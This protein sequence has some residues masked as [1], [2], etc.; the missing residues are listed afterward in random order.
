MKAIPNLRTGLYL[1]KKLVTKVEIL[2]ALK[3]GVSRQQVMKSYDVKRSTLR[4]R[5]YRPSRDLQAGKEFIDMKEEH[6]IKK[7]RWGS[8][9]QA[10]AVGAHNQST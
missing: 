7:R 8:G 10:T 9:D 6:Y 4:P 2:R 3:D 5:T 1:A